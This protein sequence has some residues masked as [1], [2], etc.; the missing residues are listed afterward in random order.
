MRN[1]AVIFWLVF[2]QFI[3]AQET[4]DFKITAKEAHFQDLT[5]SVYGVRSK[6]LY[7]VD[8][9]GKI[10]ER[11]TSNLKQPILFQNAKGFIPSVFLAKN[12]SIIFYKRSDTLYGYELPTKKEVIKVASDAEIFSSGSYFIFKKFDKANNNYI[13]SVLNLRLK[14]VYEFTYFTNFTNIAFSD[15]LEQVALVTGNT[16]SGQNLV[17][18]DCKTNEKLK[19]ISLQVGERVEFVFYN[20]FQTKWNFLVFD[21]L[22]NQI[23]YHKDQDVTSNKKATISLKVDS[24]FNP[25]LSFFKHE[26]FY[27]FVLYDKFLKPIIFKCNQQI[28]NHFLDDF[29]DHLVITNKEI[30]AFQ[31]KL[32]PNSEQMFRKYD[33]E[34]LALKFNEGTDHNHKPFYQAKFLKDDS[35]LVKENFAFNPSVFKY[36][37]KGTFYNRFFQQ[38]F[39][40]YLESKHSIEFPTIK[41]EENLTGKIILEARKKGNQND[42]FYFEYDL[43]TDK[44]I[45]VEELNGIKGT[46]L[47]YV[48]NKRIFLVQA[49]NKL[50]VVSNQATKTIQGSFKGVRLSLNGSYIALINEQN[51]LQ[52]LDIAND[53]KVFHS[54]N[55]IE[56]EFQV[57][58]VDQSSF[59]LN[60]QNLKEPVNQC[61]QKINFFLIDNGQLTKQENPCIYATSVA[62]SNEHFAAV[63]NHSILVNHQQKSFQSLDKK[64]MYLSSNQSGDRLLVTYEDNYV[65]ILD[66]N[67]LQ[68]IGVMFHPNQNTHAFVQGKNYFTNGDMSN[69]FDV[70][71]QNDMVNWK[72]VPN[73]F[74]NPLVVLQMFGTPN[75]AYQEALQKAIS[76]KSNVNEVNVNANIET[77]TDT[78]S[79]NLHVLAIGVSDYLQNEY[80]LTFADKDAMDMVKTFGI[81][82]PE[83]QAYY[84]DT[85][86]GKK[87]QLLNNDKVSQSI[88][89]YYERYES[90]GDFFPI[91]IE[92]YD[93]MEVSYQ[94][95][96]LFDFTQKKYKTI[97]HPFERSSIIDSN[98]KVTK[99]KKGFYFIQNEEVKIIDIVSNDAKSLTVAKE[100]FTDYAQNVNEN[101]WVKSTLNGKDWA[102]IFVDN[103]NKVQK[104]L[105]VDVSKISISL[106]KDQNHPCTFGCLTTIHQVSSD[107]SLVLFSLNYK[108]F[109]FLWDVNSNQFY[110]ITLEVADKNGEFSF[111]ADEKYLLLTNTVDALTNVLV[112]NLK[113]KLEQKFTF[114][115][116]KYSLQLVNYNK[117]GLQSITIEEPLLEENV[118]FVDNE[119]KIAEKKT[120]SF[121][122]VFTTFIINEKATKK[123][124]EQVLKDFTKNIKAEDQVIVF[125]AGHG[126]LD[127]KQQYYFAPH[128]MDFL[129]VTKNGISYEFIINS[130]NNIASKN[131]LLLMDTCH[132]GNVY[133]EV[134]GS[135]AENQRGSKVKTSNKQTTFKVG[136]I[137]KTLYNSNTS[138]NN[139][140]IISASVGSDVALEH[141]EIGNGAF[142]YS[143]ISQIKEALQT[144]S[145]SM[146][147]LNWDRKVELTKE[148]IDEVFKQ[149]G[150]ITNN[151]QTPDIREI[152]PN[153]KLKVW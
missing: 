108:D 39:S 147:E 105:S 7:T 130:L 79:Q 22:N 74:Q 127:T 103:Q 109:F 25:K 142:T 70:I 83:D 77:K 75:Q 26:N 11:S 50:M 82:S 37:E 71:V 148:F 116:K 58:P 115:E 76:L 149:V 63:F 129:N 121:D 110:P 143:F 151:K 6:K 19:D 131:K 12:D 101:L 118:L 36:F 44:L 100:L 67:T 137:V 152:N 120:A 126:V 51:Q 45:S 96:R 20:S 117:N 97:S 46:I 138:N 31:Q 145:F 81:L 13:I 111:S 60:S 21:Q 68:K 40:E 52:I 2:L 23:H 69:Y 99:N 47:D 124:V 56:A 135:N 92:G 41:F 54:E 8:A 33:V 78:E 144:S 119:K 107:G 1:I 35:W 128:D 85:Y 93:W 123:R 104:R 24:Y 17:V 146:S 136:D 114:P 133:D 16:Y 94:K 27:Q 140:T 132:S 34:S 64:I 150:S 3:L 91:A 48:S 106:D 18:Y 139:L 38:S 5:G 4:T 98:W 32:L 42:Y 95:I 65:D 72:I 59:L 53:F 80:S 125:L 49:G 57:I 134:T 141:P 84:F 102:L 112:F 88:P 153:A 43:I 14:L 66:G 73:S 30:I 29:A 28:S 89:V 10:L 87:V 9:S 62:S 113:G 86:F 15:N 61:R 122:Q 55:L 90:P